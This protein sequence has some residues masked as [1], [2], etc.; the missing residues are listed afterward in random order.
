LKGRVKK[1]HIR[2]EMVLA[3]VYKQV[4]VLTLYHLGTCI[5]CTIPNTNRIEPFILETGATD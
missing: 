1:S 2:Y 5:V 4:A 3:S